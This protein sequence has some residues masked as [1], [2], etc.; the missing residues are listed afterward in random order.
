MYSCG[1]RIGEATI[2]E[3]SAVDR[4]RRLLHIIG[5]RNAAHHW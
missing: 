4:A 1:L 2:L 3:I 5:K